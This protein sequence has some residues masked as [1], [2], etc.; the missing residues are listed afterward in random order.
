MYKVTHNS[1]KLQ[2]RNYDDTIRTIPCQRNR[3]LQS[4]HFHVA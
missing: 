1:H 4:K 2:T 3:H